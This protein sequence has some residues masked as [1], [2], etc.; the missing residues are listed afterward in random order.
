MAY[1]GHRLIMNC[2]IKSFQCNYVSCNLKR[3]FMDFADNV[4][5]D[6]HAHLCSLIWAFS[7]HQH[8]LPNPLILK[9]DHKGPDQPV[10]MRKLIRACIVL[11]LRKGHFRAL[12]ITWFKMQ[13]H[14]HQQKLSSACAYMSSLIVI[15]VNLSI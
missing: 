12:R 9:L 1:I 3:V 4:G 10:L 6:Q 15:Y 13:A 7:D 5:P 8:I 14:V 2:L 11:K